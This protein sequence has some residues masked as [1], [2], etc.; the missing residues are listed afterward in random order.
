MGDERK[1]SFQLKEKGKKKKGNSSA[2]NDRKEE[3]LCTGGN[4]LK[5][6]SLTGC[7]IELREEGERMMCN[8]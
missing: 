7:E 5:G 2:T 1:N 8:I 6:I 3:T 4:E